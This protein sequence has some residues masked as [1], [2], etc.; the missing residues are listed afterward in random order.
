M[1]LYKCIIIIITIIIIISF[2]SATNVRVLCYLLAQCTL[3]NAPQ[4]QNFTDENLAPHVMMV[5]NAGC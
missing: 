2:A 5:I 3:V 4:R 1:V